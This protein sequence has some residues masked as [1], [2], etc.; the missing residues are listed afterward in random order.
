VSGAGQINPIEYINL[1]E[2]LNIGRAKNVP[3]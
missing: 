3:H 1:A 2:G